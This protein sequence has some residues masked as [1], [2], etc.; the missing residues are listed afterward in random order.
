MITD[1]HKYLRPVIPAK[2]GI[3]CVTCAEGADS[4]ASHRITTWVPVCAG[5][6]KGWFYLCVSVFIYG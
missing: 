3:Q 6:T 1:E 4:N 2:T 5:T